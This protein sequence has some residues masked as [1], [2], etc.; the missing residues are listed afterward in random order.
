MDLSREDPYRP[1]LDFRGVGQNFGYTITVDL[2]GP[3]DAPNL[4]FQSVP[5]L[6][7]QEILLMLSAGEVPR[8]NL[9]Y[10]TVDKASRVGLYVGREFVNRF[11]G[12]TSTS[13]RLVLRS[14]E[15]V[16]DEG[17]LTYSL[18]YRFTDRWSVFSE[19][20]RFRDFNSGLR[21]KVLSR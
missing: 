18:E 12:N 1:Y 4:T 3:A 13:E 20:N 15:Q 11:V 10:S 2:S 16:T 17:T 21:L 9:D 8:S 19:Y 7:A 5:P 6:T 14:G